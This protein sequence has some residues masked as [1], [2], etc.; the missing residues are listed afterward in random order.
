MLLS[1]RGAASKKNFFKCEKS[2]LVVFIVSSRQIPRD[3][4]KRDTIIAV[5]VGIGLVAFL[6]SAILITFEHVGSRGVHGVIVEKRS[7]VEP[8]TEISVGAGG[9][10]KEDIPGEFFFIVRDQIKG[11]VFTLS[12]SKSVFDRYSEGDEYFFAPR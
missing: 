4:S 1:R 11:T 8:V 7:V 2:L 5:V 10:K 9:L 3:T 12:V 6:V